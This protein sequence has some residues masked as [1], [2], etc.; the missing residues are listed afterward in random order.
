IIRRLKFCRRN[1]ADRLEKPAMVEPVDPFQRRVLNSLEVPPR[2]A[3]VNDFGLEQTDD[4]F[5]ERVVVRIA[6]AAHPW[7]CTCLGQTFG[8]PDRQILTA[9]V[10]VMHDTLDPGARPNRLLQRIEN[11]LGVHRARHPPSH[12]PAS[13][14]VDHE[15]DVH[16]P[17]PG[18]DVGEVRDPKLVGTRRL[19]L[20]IDVIQRSLGAVVRDRGPT[21]APTHRALQSQRTHQTLDRTA[22]HRNLF[23]VQLSPH[24]ARAVD[25]EVVVP[26]SANTS[27][28]LAVPAHARRHPT[29]I[30]L[31][32]LVLVVRRR[33]DRQLRA[34][35]LDPVCVAMRVDE[36]DHDF[37]RRSSSAWAKNADALRRISLARRNSCTS[38]SSAFTRSR[39]SLVTP[40]R[41][42]RSR[43]NWRTQRRNDSLVQPIFS[44]IETMAAHCDP[45]SAAW[46]STSRTARSCTSAGYLFDVLMTPSSQEMESPGI[47]GRFTQ[48]RRYKLGT[49]PILSDNS[50]RL[51]PLQS[52]L[53]LFD[54][55]PRPAK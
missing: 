18:R 30:N 6:Y 40:G 27:S 24:L 8:I 49:P 52:R 11:Q 42:P 7:L 45:C 2:T 26:N 55:R 51:G 12:D 28:E 21:L 37:P 4:G 34:D 3:A 9:A 13:E 1:V 50:Y 47:P 16:E 53:E 36:R 17:A 43:S 5:G 54:T 39:S 48:Q 10:A 38:R 14:H 32:A 31:P 29:R 33:G 41:R 22:R 46:S 23:P 25:L 20:T 15:R 44:A 19:E 35:R